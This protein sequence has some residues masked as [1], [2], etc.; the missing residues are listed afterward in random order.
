MKLWDL[1]MNKVV[2]EFCRHS[3]DITGVKFAGDLCVSVSKDG[4][5]G[6]WNY[7][8]TNG[9]NNSKAGARELYKLPGCSL[10]SAVEV[11]DIQPPGVG[12]ENTVIKLAISSFDGSIAIAN[13]MPSLDGLEVIFSSPAHQMSSDASKLL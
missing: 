13:L 12:S 6:C 11:L 4:S 3:F 7:L 2:D 10:S 8:R 9:I 5:L 1:R